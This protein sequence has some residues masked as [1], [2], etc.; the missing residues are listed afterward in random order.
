MPLFASTNAAAKSPT[1]KEILLLGDS[2]LAILVSSDTGLKLLKSQHPFLLRAVPCQRL[3]SF[4]CTKQS[5]SSA[6]H[7]LKQE[8][9]R[10]SRVVVVATGYNDYQGLSFEKSVRAISAEAASQ[11]LEVMWLTYKVGGNV[12][13]KSRVFNQM[14]FGLAKKIQNLTIMDWNFISA[15]HPEYFRSDGVHMT[16]V[17]G[18]EIAKAISD[19]LDKLPTASVATT[20]AP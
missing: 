15:G 17:G 2:V 3:D 18:I 9:G 20:V 5:R 4:G 1:V 10:F 8:R 7:I 16:A 14:L 12:K 11:G 19:A 13:E 6:L